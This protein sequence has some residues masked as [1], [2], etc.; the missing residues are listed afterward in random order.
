M[1]LQVSELKQQLCLKQTGILI[2]FIFLRFCGGAKL[3]AEDHVFLEQLLAT[4]GWDIELN[5]EFEMLILLEKDPWA[6]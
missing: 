6:L 5:E 3:W 2:H 4:F 1:S